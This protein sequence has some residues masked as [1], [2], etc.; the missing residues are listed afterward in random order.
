MVGT[1]A[2]ARMALC[3]NLEVIGEGSYRVVYRQGN[4][5]YKVEYDEGITAHANEYEWENYNGYPH[6]DGD[7]IGIPDMELYWVDGIPVIA[8]SFIEGQLMGEC[9]RSRYDNHDSCLPDNIVRDLSMHYDLAYGNV[10]FDG[11]TY[12][13]VDV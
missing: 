2:G 6:F 8:A 11:E 7:H 12:W 4:V 5:V 3:D 10:I 13:I 9:T 1:L